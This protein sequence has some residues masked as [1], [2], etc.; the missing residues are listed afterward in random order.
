MRDSEGA[1]GGSSGRGLHGSGA[2]GRCGRQR[3]R[4]RQSADGAGAARHLLRLEP[5]GA[6]LRP[7]RHARILGQLYPAARKSRRAADDPRPAA[8]YPRTPPECRGLRRGDHG[9]DAAR[10]Q[11]RRI[12]EHLLKL[13]YSPAEQLRF[14]W[15]ETIVGARQELF[16]KLTPTLRREIEGALEKLYGDARRRATLGL[17]RYGESESAKR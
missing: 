17:Q 3:R 4:R 8:I 6:R 5:A 2:G 7:R 12:I 1:A 16:D 14:D 13:T 15:M 9:G 11:I 10:S